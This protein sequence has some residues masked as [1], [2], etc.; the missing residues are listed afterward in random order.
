M[1]GLRVA[2]N[3]STTLDNLFDVE[4]TNSSLP[5]AINANGV[6]MKTHDR[7]YNSSPL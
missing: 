2:S 6:Y 7:I 3:S 4:L 5:L 1:H